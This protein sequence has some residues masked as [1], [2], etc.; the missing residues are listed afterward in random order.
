[1]AK[2]ETPPELAQWIEERAA[3]L[4]KT[5]RRIQSKADAREDQPVAEWLLPL[6]AEFS[7]AESIS[8]TVAFTFSLRTRCG[9]RFQR[10]RPR[11][12]RA[13]D[14]TVS[15]AASRAASRLA[16]ETWAE[17]WPEKP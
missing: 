10:R 13:T 1:M 4:L 17:V 2:H 14:V 3:L 6:L 7:H 8:E 5:A 15:A 12:A 16:R 9:T 11:L